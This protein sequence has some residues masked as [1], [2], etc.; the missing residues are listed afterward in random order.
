[1]IPILISL[2]LTA[3]GQPGQDCNNRMGN[4]CRA[5]VRQAA[6]GT[7]PLA[8]FEFANAQGYGLP[9]VCSPPNWLQWSEQ[10]QNVVWNT[11]SSVV[12]LP[13]ITPD[14]ATAPDGTPTA[15]RVV[16]PATTGTQYSIVYQTALNP[17]GPG[18]VAT[19]SFWVKGNAQSGTLHYHMQVPIVSGTCAYSAS[20]WVQCSVS[21]T[22]SGNS[23]LVIG[24]DSAD[25]GA[26]PWAAADVFLW[27]AAVNI[28]SSAAP[29]TKT[30][31]TAAGPSVSGA[32]GEPVTWTRGSTAYCTRSAAESSI[33]NGDLVL[34]ANN[35]PRVMALGGPLG[36][37]VES[38]RTNP[39][40]QSESLDNAAW[41]LTASGVANPTV[42]PNAATAPNGT[43]TAERVQIPAVTAA[44]FSAIEQPA[45][46]CPNAL[47]SA[48]LFVR[49]NATSG[50]IS[51]VV[52]SPVVC[53]SC[54]YNSTGWSRCEPASFTLASGGL[55]L[56]GNDGV[57]C[58]SGQGAQDVFIWG[59]QCEA[60]AYAT[61]YMPTASVGVTRSPETAVASLTMPQQPISIAWTSGVA[62]P[63]AATPDRVG[64]MLRALAGSGDYSAAYFQSQFRADVVGTATNVVTGAGTSV[65]GDRWAMSHTVSGVLTTF[66]NSNQTG[67]A[68]LA[69]T[70]T[71]AT[72]I[73]IGDSPAG[74]SQLDGI[75]SR[76]CVD[77]S[78]S[79]C[80]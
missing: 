15:D 76:V 26:T 52:G 35:Q 79:R 56:V 14:Q 29:Y 53:L 4:R 38:S 33:A 48:S 37:L 34:M 31:G 72:V 19:G 57:D 80:R 46:A 66:K 6:R 77:P 11:G 71:G 45:G 20:T 54:A 17:A 13:T 27:G 74:A 8:F 1:M 47:D 49:G 44:Q 24:Q 73:G 41:T 51:L 25:T 64:V 63:A 30:V 32:K 2:L 21:Y 9:P 23:V 42:T 50:T 16:F 3:H 22:A 58:G 70:L 40:L 5:G 12:A 78:P 62:L 28:G 43:L 39:V 7:T 67:T 69:N 36:V 61:S 10:L 18:M 68:T 55:F 65:V 59:T 75:N 60:G